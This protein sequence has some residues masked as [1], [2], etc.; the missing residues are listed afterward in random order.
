MPTIAKSFAKYGVEQATLSS[1]S[2]RHKALSQANK[3]LEK[4]AKY[5]SVDDSNSETSNQNWWSGKPSGGKR[6]IT[7]RYD[8]KV[9]PD[10]SLW[11]GDTLEQVKEGVEILKKIMQE[12]DESEWAREEERRREMPLKNN[13]S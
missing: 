11:S 1:S 9:F 13:R 7:C 6:R 10:L 3:M 2:H 5:S 12:I 4:L 8:S